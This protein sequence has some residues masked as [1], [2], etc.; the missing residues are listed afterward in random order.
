MKTQKLNRKQKND[1]LSVVP[2]T[3]RKRTGT[4]RRYVNIRAVMIQRIKVLKLRIVRDNEEA[5][6]LQD[7]LNL[8]NPKKGKVI[9]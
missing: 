8:L 6:T 2:V 5:K 1:I 4:A 3:S 9:K 7:A